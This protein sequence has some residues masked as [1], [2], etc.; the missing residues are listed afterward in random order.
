MKSSQNQNKKGEIEVAS[1]LLLIE[2]INYAK[3]KLRFAGA[4]V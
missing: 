1:F 3:C 2:F 4:L